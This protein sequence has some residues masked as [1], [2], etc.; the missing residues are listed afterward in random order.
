MKRSV[1]VISMC[2][3]VI[4]GFSFSFEGSSNSCNQSDNIDELSQSDNDIV[5]MINMVNESLVWGYLV[6]LV[7]FGP[8]YTGTNECYKLSDRPGQ[9]QRADRY[10]QCR[11]NERFHCKKTETDSGAAPQIAATADLRLY[12]SRP[13]PI[14]LLPRKQPAGGGPAL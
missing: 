9:L 10:F 3:L 4:P 7:D 11:R 13:Q 8:R 2:I 12:L 5:E 6:G 1:A 14:R